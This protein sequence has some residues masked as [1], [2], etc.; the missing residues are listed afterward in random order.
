GDLMGAASHDYVNDALA[1]LVAAL[2]VK[3]DAMQARL[4]ALEGRGLEYLGTH[5]RA[6]PYRR[7]SAVT[8]DGS[9]FIAVRQVAEGEVP[10][11]SDGWQLAVKRGSD[12]RTKT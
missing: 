2:K 4:D 8:H 5:Q 1:D 3:L 7:G 6:Q 11:K 12:G 10:G 9:L